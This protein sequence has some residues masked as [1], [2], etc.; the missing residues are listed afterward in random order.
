MVRKFSANVA[1]QKVYEMLNEVISDLR[2]NHAIEVLEVVTNYC[3][4][5]LV[6]FREPPQ[7][8]NK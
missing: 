1:A 4:T 3:E 6:A 5:L 2:K 7:E 8:E